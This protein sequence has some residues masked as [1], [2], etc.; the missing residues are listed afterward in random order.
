[1][2]KWNPHTHLFRPDGVQCVSIQTGGLPVI[3]KPNLVLSEELKGGVVPAAPKKTAGRERRVGEHQPVRL[4]IMPFRGNEERK[5]R[6]E[7][8]VFHKTPKMART[9][10]G[11]G[12]KQEPR[13]FA[14][15]EGQL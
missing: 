3:Q 7:L 15:H 1:V 11:C 14:A 6:R 5:D 10:V 9:R 4:T 2:R 12:N 13:N 8:S